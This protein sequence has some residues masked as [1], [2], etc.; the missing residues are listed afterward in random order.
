MNPLVESLIAS[1]LLASGLSRSC[2]V[3]DIDSSILLHHGGDA[4]DWLKLFGVPH[5]ES[6]AR[7]LISDGRRS[8]LEANAWQFLVVQGVSSV[9]LHGDLSIFYCSIS[10]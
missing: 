4:D 9:T 7:A 3:N 2:A 5:A 8:E 6:V 10:V 1:F